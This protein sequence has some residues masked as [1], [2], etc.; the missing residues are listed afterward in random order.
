MSPTPPSSSTPLQVAPNLD[1]EVLAEWDP[2]QEDEDAEHTEAE[3]EEEECDFED[4]I[5]G[6]G[7]APW[8]TPRRPRPGLSLTVEEI[9]MVL[10]CYSFFSQTKNKKEW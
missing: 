9:E 6:Q 4:D 2:S 7:T 5:A 3:D 10:N 1:D 8:A